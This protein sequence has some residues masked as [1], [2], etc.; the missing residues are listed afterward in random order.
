MSSTI[1]RHWQAGW[2]RAL[3]GRAASPVDVVHAARGPLGP[4][5]VRL[6]GRPLWLLA[7][8]AVGAALLTQV[9][10]TQWGG[11]SDEHA[12]WLAARRLIDG[13]PLYD[14]AAT[15]VTPY[16][17]LYPPVLAQVLVPVA[18]LV[19]SELF[20]ALWTAGMLLAL[21]WL[22]GRDVVRALAL[23]AFLPVA[24]E[25]WFRNIHLFLAVLVV[26]GLRA[27]PTA[28]AAAAAIKV[29]P[30]LAVPWLVGRGRWR[31]ATAVGVAG[32]LILLVSVAAAPDQWLAWVDFMRSQDPFVPSSFLPLAFPVR[33]VAGL[34][35]AV[36]AARLPGWRGE[37]GLVVAIVV[38]LPSL[39]FTGLSL[40]VAIVPLFR[41][42]ERLA[43]SAG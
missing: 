2:R 8:A 13:Q 11:P 28:L 5:G 14:A 17:Y 15:I 4:L 10:L 42:R 6:A 41:M 21:W 39:W 7:L 25:F 29:S 18:W 33:L 20:A 32:C 37:A 43:A 23:V 27:A 34:L 9:A 26:M 30:A 19:P 22:A 36:L 3:A 38:A 24:M 1:G 31:D 40:L 16:A 12:Y 35:L